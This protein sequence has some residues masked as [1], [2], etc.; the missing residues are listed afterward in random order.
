MPLFTM[1]DV[2]RMCSME[3]GLW[4]RPRV[5]HGREFYLT[6]YIQENL[7][8]SRGDPNICRIFRL[9]LLKTI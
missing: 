8:A 5:D 2:Y 4:D 7:R 1:N 3:Y 6:L 9:R